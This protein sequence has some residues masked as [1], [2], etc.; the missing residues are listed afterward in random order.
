[1]DKTAQ[2]VTIKIFNEVNIEYNSIVIPS[3]TDTNAGAN[4]QVGKNLIT[5]F[6]PLHRKY[7][8]TNFEI[9]EIDRNFD[10]TN[11]KNYLEFGITTGNILS[12]GAGDKV[13]IKITDLV[14]T[15]F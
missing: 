4:F 5:T 14:G 6:Q 12:Q 8:N 1:M 15:E 13:A 9:V 2:P 3:V 11:T 7:T 10:G